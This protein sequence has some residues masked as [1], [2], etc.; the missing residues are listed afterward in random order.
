MATARSSPG[1]LSWQIQYAGNAVYNAVTAPCIKRT[2]KA[3]STATLTVHD[4]DHAVVSTAPEGTWI[5]FRI[6]I[7]GE[8]GTPD[9]AAHVRAFS[10]GT[11]AG[12]GTIIALAAFTNGL[13]HDV[14]HQYV[15]DDP[16]TVSYRA[17][18]HGDESYVGHLSPCESITVT[19]G[20]ANR[21][22]DAEANPEADCHT[23]PRHDRRAR[24]DRCRRRFHVSAGGQRCPGCI[25]GAGGEPGFGIELERRSCGS[26]WATRSDER[27]RPGSG[28]RRADLA[29]R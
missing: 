6:T 3:F 27:R 26:L 8:F 14:Q 1:V 13:S 2:W 29:L 12:S 18:Y 19:A 5:H 16:G 15:L 21:G 10:N 24:A 7:E 17:E 4:G 28:W 23:Q 20:H 9:G 25:H 11:C 22:A